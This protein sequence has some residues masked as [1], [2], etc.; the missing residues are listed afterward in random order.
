MTSK[1]LEKST[2]QDIYEKI[3]DDITFG[4]FTSGERLKEE[5]LSDLYGVSRS[6]IREALRQL[7]SEGLISFERNKGIEVIKLSARQMEEI[8]DVRELLESQ[9][10]KMAVA[11]V[12]KKEIAYL[13]GLYRKMIK[14]AKS[15]DKQAWLENNTLFHGFFRDK[16][17]NDCLSQLIMM[18]KRRIYRY[19]YMPLSYPHVIETYAKHH[20]ALIE[21]CKK[22]NAILAEKIMR[23]HVRTV[24]DVVTKDVVESFLSA[25]R[26]QR[27]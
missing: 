20:A 16:A 21:C 1:H 12:T 23:L 27:I 11:K 19:Q 22:K 9:A 3:R 25:S 17:D 15:Q 2:R 13:E 14:A 4:R 5:K 7:E 10:V 18:L 26:K 24:K 6:P 8:Y